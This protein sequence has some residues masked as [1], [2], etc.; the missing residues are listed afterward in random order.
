MNA[1]LEASY[2]KLRP[3]IKNKLR[4]YIEIKESPRYFNSTPSIPL[5]KEAG[6]SFIGAGAALASDDGRFLPDS[7]KKIPNLK[8]WSEIISAHN[9]LGLIATEWARSGTLSPPNAPFETRW[10]TVLAMAEHSWTGGKTDDKHFDRKFCRR[11]F[12]LSHLRL[13]DALYFLR[14]SNE[15]FAPLALNILETLKPE[16]KRNIR[17]YEALL[18][19][20]SLLCM[21]M[22]FNQT[23]QNYFIPL[24]YKIM[25]KTLHKSQEARIKRYLEEMETAFNEQESSAGKI[26]SGT[27]PEQ[28]VNEYLKCIFIPKREMNNF[29]G[30]L[31]EG[32]SVSFK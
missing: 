19:A 12:G 2:E 16:V 23:W 31:L 1:G 6:L 15:R 21:N 7:G 10:H 22:R 28:E 26:F 11:L 5:I 18:S 4:K 20:A 14:V 9:G 13:M 30:N 25:D 27:M 8:A 24:L 3:A 32:N 29:I 17:K